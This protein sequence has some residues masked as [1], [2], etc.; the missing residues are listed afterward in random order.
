MR[1]S[2]R[3]WGSIRG[4]LGVGRDGGTEMAVMAVTEAGGGVLPV[5]VLPGFKQE[6]RHT[7]VGC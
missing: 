7:E 2:L 3:D 4:A 6:K 1:P 5:P